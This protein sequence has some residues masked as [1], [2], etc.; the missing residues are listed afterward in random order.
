L[1]KQLPHAKA[2]LAR[3]LDRLD[4]IFDKIVIAR[5]API[6]ANEYATLGDSRDLRIPNA[7]RLA[8]S[9]RRSTITLRT[10]HRSRR[11]LD[12]SNRIP[13]NTGLITEH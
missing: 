5:L 3:R 6:M 1:K 4:D 9:P 2:R 8:G 7:R 13:R 11:A 12:S 10:S